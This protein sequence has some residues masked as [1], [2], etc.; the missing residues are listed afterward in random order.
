MTDFN[1]VPMETHEER[2][3][4]AQRMDELLALI[5]AEGFMARD[6]MAWETARCMPQ[7][8]RVALGDDP[9]EGGWTAKQELEAQM[10]AD[11]DDPSRFVGAYYEY[12]AD[13]AALAEEYGDPVH[14]I[15]GIEP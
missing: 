9:V 5:R 15:A 14:A 8:A 1:T 4:A 7:E 11:L 2:M 13:M 3:K 6:I 10:D 12:V